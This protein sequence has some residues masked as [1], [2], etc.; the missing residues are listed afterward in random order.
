MHGF[1][2]G[3]VGEVRSPVLFALSQAHCERNGQEHNGLRDTAVAAGLCSSV[4]VKQD[5]QCARSSFLK[6]CV[7]TTRCRTGETGTSVP[8]KGFKIGD[9]FFSP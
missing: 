9:Y 8:A 1:Q 4:C 3:R 7:T 6:R 2:V 5:R